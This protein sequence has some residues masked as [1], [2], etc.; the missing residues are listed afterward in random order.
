MLKDYWNK[1]DKTCRN[2]FYFDA[3]RGLK[4]CKKCRWQG[5]GIDNIQVQANK[6]RLKRG[7]EPKITKKQ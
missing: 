1:R 4:V 2:C 7:K 3:Y 6:P 5:Y